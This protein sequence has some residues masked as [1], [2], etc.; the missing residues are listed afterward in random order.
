MKTTWLLQSQS[1]RN[2]LCP[3]GGSAAYSSASSSLQ[4][5]VV[6]WHDS[7][8]HKF[9][10][11]LTYRCVRRSDQRPHAPILSTSWLPHQAPNF[12]CFLLHERQQR[13]GRVGPRK[14]IGTLHIVPTASSSTFLG[15]LGS[16]GLLSS[17]Y[18]SKSAAPDKYTDLAPSKATAAFTGLCAAWDLV[19]PISPLTLS[20]WFLYSW[21]IWRKKWTN[22]FFVT[23]FEHMAQYCRNAVLNLS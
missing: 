23:R 20:S 10:H 18:C 11:V 19:T 1:C 6:C 16:E 3:L 2:K 5:C 22:A 21:P 15:W 8:Q 17:D 9:R 4:A 12:S 13:W 14:R 7:Q